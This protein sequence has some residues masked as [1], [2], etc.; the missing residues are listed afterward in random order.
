[1]H[2]LVTGM[3]RSGTSLLAE[4]LVRAGV[5]FGSSAHWLPADESN[6]RGYFEDR[7]VVNL[8]D[9]LLRIWSGTWDEPPPLPDNWLEDPNLGPLADEASKWLRSMANKPHWGWKDPRACLL[10]PF[11][12]RLSPGLHCVLCI[13]DP[14]EVARSLHKRDRVTPHKASFLW[15]HYV[16]E[17]F[18]GVGDAPCA[19]FF[20]DDLL[21]DPARQLDRLLRFCGI[22]SRQ[23]LGAC[24]GVVEPGLRRQHAES[25]SEAGEVPL[26]WCRL[27]YRQLRTLFAEDGRP[28]PELCEEAGGA[29]RIAL[30]LLLAAPEVRR[31]QLRITF[32][33]ME[34]KLKFDQATIDDLHIAHGRAVSLLAEKEQEITTARHAIVQRD[35]MAAGL[36]SSLQEIAKHR[37]CALAK[38]REIEEREARS[39]ARI[40][41]L[42][43][44]LSSVRAALD[45]MNAER[46]LWQERRRQ[47]LGLIG[48]RLAN[49]HGVWDRL[50]R[51]DRMRRSEA[52]L[53][54]KL[55]LANALSAHFDAPSFDHVEEGDVRFAGWC[56]H[57]TREVTSLSL[58][59]NGTSYPA[60][61]GLDRPDVGAAFPQFPSSS[62]S[63]F[64]VSVPLKP[65][66]Y[67]ATLE[68]HCGESGVEIFVA[69]RVLTVTPRPTRKRAAD[70]LER[71]VGFAGYAAM[72]F[73]R[74]L[75][76]GKGFPSLREIPGQIRRARQEYGRRSGDGPALRSPDG[77]VLPAPVD[78]YVAWLAD[79]RW[80]PR[81]EAALRERLGAAANLPK[82]S[83]VTPVYRPSLDHFL[84][85]AASVRGQVYD[86]WEW[87]L[88]DDASNDSALTDALKEL[89]AQDR[90]VRLVTRGENGHISVATNSAAALASGEFIALLD[91]DDLLSPDCLAE[92]ALCLAAHDDVDVLYSDDDKVNVDGQRYGPQFKPDWSPESL[93][94]QM[95][96]SHL[97]VVR[98]TLYEAVGGMRAGFEGSQDHDLALR[99]V[100]KAR[101]VAHLPLVLY[102]W[103]AAEGSTA[104]SG[105]AKTYSFDAGMRAVAEA[106]ARRGVPAKADRPDWA[107]QAKASLIR[108]VFPDDGPRVAILIA[109][110]NRVELV[111]QC[112][113]SLAKTRYRNYEIVIID[114]HS[115]DPETLT[116]LAAFPGRVLRSPEP[117]EGFNYAALHNFAAREVDVPYLLLLNN[118][119]EARSPEWLSQM[120]GFARLPGVGAVGARLLFP[121]RTVQHAGILNGFNQGSLAL[122]F[123]GLPE[124]DPGYLA[125][126]RVCRNYA[127]VTAACLLTP[128]EL[129]LALGGFD[130]KNFPVSLNDVDYCYRLVDAGYRCVYA[131]EAE[132]FHHE[133]ASRGI[134]RRVEEIARFRQRYR[135][136]SEPYYNANLGTANERFEIWPR[137]LARW[138]K[139]PVKAMMVAHTLDLTGAPICQFEMAAALS[140]REQVAPVV[141]SLED[142]P[143]RSLYEARG[144]PVRI[145]PD[146]LGKVA[147]MADYERELAAF[148]QLVLDADVEVVYGNTLK[149]FFAMDA[150]RRLNLPSLWNIRES[151]PWQTYFSHLPAAV[152][153]RALQCFTFPYRVLFVS[154]A[155]RAV[156]EPLNSQHNFHVIHDGLDLEQWEARLAGSTRAGSRAR[157]G[158][159]ADELAVMLVGTV[160]ERKGQHDLVRAMALLEPRVAAR[161]RCFIVGDRPGDYSRGLAGL[162]HKLPAALRQRVH[163]IPETRDVAE[164]YQ[165]ADLFVC[166]SRVESYPRVT[167]EAMACGLP[168]ISTPVYGLAEQ[169]VHGA[170]ALLY[171]PGDLAGLAETLNRVCEDDALRRSMADQSRWVLAGLTSFDE[172][173]D[174]YAVQ[175]IEAREVC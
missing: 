157:L 122:A 138:P 38:L 19:V 74:R 162:V 156:F 14:L 61:W 103:R 46:G 120:M 57:P 151:E 153:G 69:P 8:D 93:L 113:E 100:E 109:T 104:L 91:H 116:W 84:E 30:G 34:R 137:H 147:S 7:R 49:G 132:L 55:L 105:D 42:M 16:A 161:L 136:R 27:V 15:L 152:A 126:A 125:G 134:G 155:S 101:R 60:R 9:R 159:D 80:S 115:D 83:V 174:E 78:P 62:Y 111:K 53:A 87:C 144:I 163:V 172:M 140:D 65:G 139:R 50:L 25:P 85:T 130:E 23:V 68:A 129:Y 71:S 102:H 89:A 10:L 75:R 20:Y 36:E 123:R 40:D 165:A 31:E 73:R 39:E 141:V 22:E 168:V 94:S 41:R 64:L 86:H 5:D 24:L 54:G 44:E 6:P 77:F 82:I 11:W 175:F 28:L 3:H 21:K 164:Y 114:D 18:R 124:Q 70:M 17:S 92:V 149:T 88:A 48:A 146:L 167:L 51:S 79:N 160:C 108:H 173:V 33:E 1:M 131:A 35:L 52:D 118:D 32:G 133:S 107:V 145:V 143:I 43:Q 12:R 121:D 148:S 58:C 96:F 171:Q 135:E 63:G 29:A 67:L 56:L 112:V 95:Y 170:N 97:F 154:N 90:R 119:T 166:T 127:A 169:L 117:R 142:G 2:T 81:Q 4:I 158:I 45:E 128:R 72:K 59:L 37:D 76:S 13:R 66:R 26:E 106:L 98:R 150:A 99:V 110:R 47:V